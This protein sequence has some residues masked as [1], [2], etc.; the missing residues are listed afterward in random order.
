MILIL[1]PKDNLNKI[2]LEAVKTFA[3]EGETLLVVFEDGTTRNYPLQHLWYY[4]S[5]VENHSLT[6][7]KPPLDRS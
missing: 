7:L 5:N 1:S 6:T 4:Q 3:L 2:T